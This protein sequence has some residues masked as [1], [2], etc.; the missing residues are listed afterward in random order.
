MCYHLSI[1]VT[2]NIIFAL[3]LSFSGIRENVQNEISVCAMYFYIMLWLLH[4]HSAK[5]SELIWH[6]M[7]EWF[8][9]TKHLSTF[10]KNMV[11]I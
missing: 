1:S 2:S 5:T 11:Q 3:G 4:Q 9:N 6:D 10:G 8:M 7:Y